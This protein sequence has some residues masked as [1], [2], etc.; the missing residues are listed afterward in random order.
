VELLITPRRRRAAGSLF[1]AAAIHAAVVL[2][3]IEIGRPHLQ[4]DKQQNDSERR[5]QRIWF[6]GDGGGGGG[7]G[8]HDPAPAGGLQRR[9]RDRAS[10]PESAPSP[11]Q[12]Q[13]STRESEPVDRVITPLIDAGDALSSIVG[14]IDVPVSA[15]LS[16]GPGSGP[17]AGGGAGAGDGP[18]RGPGY[19]D[20]DGGNTGGGP[21][22]EGTPGVSRPVATNIERPRYTSEAMR[23]RVQGTAIVEC[24][25]RL[26][27]ACSDIRVVQS[28][29]SSFGLDEEAKRA[30]ALWRFRPGTRFGQPVPVLIRIELQFA[31]R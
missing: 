7:G 27:G 11:V 3:L 29:D 1:A 9:R 8:D 24:I 13:L 16:R 21:Y 20:G 22:V 4:R 12:A 6:A 15:A 2:V 30:V 19:G 5:N 17:G 26:N 10:V 31:L 25:V 23:A 18:G 14:L 28:I